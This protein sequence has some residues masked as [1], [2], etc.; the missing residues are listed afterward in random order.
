[1]A[2]TYGTR[3][4]K[5]GLKIQLG[6]DPWTIVDFQHVSPGKGHA[7]TKVKAKNLKN[8]KVVEYNIKSG[9]RV[10][11]PELEYRRA[12]FMYHADSFFYFMDLENYEEIL[13]NEEEVFEQKDF[14]I[15][16]TEVRLL[17]FEK[18]CIGIELE[19]QVLSLK[20]V[21]AAPGLKGDTATG[22]T[23]IVQL[24]TGLSLSVP[25]HIREGDRIKI[26]TK[27]KEYIEKD[28]TDG[29]SG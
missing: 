24:E 12:S 22:G 20:V 10:L 5:K 11:K 28:K 23:K 1:M 8:Q 13:I 14:L 21:E 27:T 17:Y 19:Q 26:N 7:F 15:D 2:I 4:F 16:Q 6:E 9:E 29:F 3:D 25:L 18:Q